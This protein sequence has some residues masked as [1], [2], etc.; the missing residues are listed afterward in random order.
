MNRIRDK[1]STEKKL[2]ERKLTEPSLAIYIYIY[3]YILFKK[4]HGCKKLFI[5]HLHG[6]FFTNSFGRI[7]RRTPGIAF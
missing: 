3:I 6:A 2:P 1:V 5:I 4:G 7:S